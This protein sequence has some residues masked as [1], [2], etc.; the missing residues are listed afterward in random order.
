[1]SLIRRAGRRALKLVGRGPHQAP[2]LT[3]T[4][5]GFG[6]GFAIRHV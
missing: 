5:I 6:V 2:V 3:F 4:E 1:M